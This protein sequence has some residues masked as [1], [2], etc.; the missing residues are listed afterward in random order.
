MV[1]QTFKSSGCAERATKFYNEYSE[2]SDFFLK[3]REI[4]FSKKKPRR[5]E[6]NNN[7]VRY[8]EN[9][10]EPLHYPT[11]FEGVIMSV[12][13]RFPYSSELRHQVVNTWNKYKQCLRV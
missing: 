13:D 12:A 10:I 3:I 1:L 5:I 2:V 7:L 11:A 9:S 8:N 6:L 4:V